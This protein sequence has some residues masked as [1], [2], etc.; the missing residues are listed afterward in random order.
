MEIRFGPYCL[1]PDRHELLGPE[2]PVEV[3][4]QVFAL[5]TLL[6]E[7]ADRVVSKDEIIDV[8][9][10]GRIISDASLNSRINAV[11]RAVG[12]DGKAQAIIR[13]YP[14][15]GF[16]FVADVEPQST[17]GSA[18]EA[19]GRSRVLVSPFQNQSSDAELNHLCEALT[20]DVISEL[21]HGAQFIITSRR[22]AYSLAD[23]LGDSAAL[24]REHGVRY[25]IE[26]GARRMGNRLRIA[27]QLSNTETDGVL[28]S[29]HYL[30]DDEDLFSVAEEVTRLIAAA[31]V[32]VMQRAY[33]QRA[34]AKAHPDAWDHVLRGWVHIHDQGRMGQEDEA[35]VAREEFRKAIA[36]DPRL[37]EAYCGLAYSCFQIFGLNFPDDREARSQEAL[38]N[39]RKAFELNM[40][41][42][43]FSA[44]LGL[45]LVHLHKNDEGTTALRRALSIAPSDT[46]MKARLGLA[47]VASGQLAEAREVLLQANEIGKLHS[48]HGVA[49][50][51]LAMAL[52]FDGAPLDAEPYAREAVAN[53]KTQFWANVALI[54]SLVGQ[55]RLEEAATARKDMQAFRRELTIS[56]VAELSPLVDERLLAIMLDGL[57]AAGLPD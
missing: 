21:S 2:G 57:R 38:I 17:A 19:A 25:V 47:L 48:S 30:R 51:W 49:T 39:A 35:R 14:R 33:R 28:W 8:V 7:N 18:L 32:P 16:R 50:V 31:V 34:L 43:E 11:R 3:E 45:V 22:A 15:R 53:P 4:P 37:P 10:D 27:A 9:W 46:H 54:L 29:E 5:L 40:F 55:G 56:R 42:A 12:D 26:G 41:D 1:D 13:T 44:C 20:E 23:T 6:A 24:R 52:V 36:L